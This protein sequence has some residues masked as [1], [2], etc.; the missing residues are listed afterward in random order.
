MQHLPNFLPG[1]NVKTRLKKRW[2]KVAGCAESLAA[3]GKE[4][5]LLAGSAGDVTPHIYP[6]E[7]GSTRDDIQHKPGSSTKF[8]H[9]NCTLPN[10]WVIMS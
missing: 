4:K 10:F 3:L 6:K 5:L 9:L 8:T 7:L 1:L 2:S